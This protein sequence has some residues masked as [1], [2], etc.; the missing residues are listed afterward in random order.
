MSHFSTIKTRIHEQQLLEETLTKLGYKFEVGEQVLT[1]CEGDE[2]QS[3]DLVVDVDAG[4]H[5]IGFQRLAD[6]T[7]NIVADWWRIE[8]QTGVTEQKFV[9]FVNVGYAQ[10]ALKREAKAHGYIIEEEK[11]L[12][13]GEVEL[14]VSEPV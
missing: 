9:G 8:K 3:V 10:A 14:V 4:D 7:F 1:N 11:V 5:K 2:T 13:N 12:A 6:G